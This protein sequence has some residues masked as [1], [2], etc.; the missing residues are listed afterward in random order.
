MLNLSLIYI[1]I[2]FFV[3][4]LSINISSC[5][6]NKYV[7]EDKQDYNDSNFTNNINS[8]NQNLDSN[9]TIKLSVDNNFHMFQLKNLVL[10]KDIKI[11]DFILE[12]Q[13]YSCALY[14]TWVILLY[15]NNRYIR[16]I[17]H[18]F[19]Y[20]IQGT[21]PLK[22]N[23]LLTWC[24]NSVKFNQSSLS[25]SSNFKSLFCIKENVF[26]KTIIQGELTY[27]VFDMPSSSYSLE[28]ACDDLSFNN[29][30]CKYESKSL[31]KSLVSTIGLNTSNDIKSDLVFKFIKKA[32]YYGKLK[33]DPNN[34]S[35][36]SNFSIIGIPFL[37]YIEP[38][39]FSEY[40][41]KSEK[42]KLISN[43]IE[44]TKLGRLIYSLYSKTSD[45]EYKIDD[46][47]PFEQL[48]EIEVF[49]AFNK[50]H[51]ENNTEYV[52]DTYLGLSNDR[53]KRIKDNL[54]KLSSEEIEEY[55]ENTFYQ[56]LSKLTSYDNNKGFESTEEVL[57]HPYLLT[58]VG[59]DK[60][61]SDTAYEMNSISNFDKKIK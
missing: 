15:K 37:K 46:N 58:N 23:D 38:E 59:L 18:I 13:I 17:S 35:I 1:S 53:Y 8:G 16:K 49:K 14:E 51:L 25:N 36:Y 5:Q 41:I 24:E 57:K 29:R 40:H 27:I 56:F 4:N 22:L 2:Y 7:S 55:F 39:Q 20:S 48:S 21:F 26:T 6:N 19:K 30:I 50:Y 9:K 47:I 52:N 33:M 28:E 32:F 34:E 44:L 61:Q 43:K 11:A 45:F 60:I 3:L 31:I 42:E 54:N 10:M 12:K